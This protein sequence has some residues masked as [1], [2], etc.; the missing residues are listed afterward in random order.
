M[1]VS[2]VPTAGISGGPPKDSAEFERMPRPSSVASVTAMAAR[3]AVV[4]PVSILK[5]PRTDAR[6]TFREKATTALLAR[7]TLAYVPTFA[8]DKDP[9]AGPEAERK[10]KGVRFGV[11]QVRV[12]GNT[13]QPST[14]GSVSGGEDKEMR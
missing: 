3:S 14:A 1:P 9:N 10:K 11:D 7:G 2:A 6:L 5:P 13:P 4:V 12:F 8:E